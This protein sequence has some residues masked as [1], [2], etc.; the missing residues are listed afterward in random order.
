MQRCRD[1]GIVLGNWGNSLH[2]LLQSM[3]LFGKGSWELDRNR[4]CEFFT[5]CDLVPLDFILGQEIDID[6][7]RDK[8]YCY[9]C[10]VL[11]SIML[12]VT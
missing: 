12:C 4:E 1:R 5:H 3:W 9:I 10:L 8:R 11:S 2:S 7:Y 6:I